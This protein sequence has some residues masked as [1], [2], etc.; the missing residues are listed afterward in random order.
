MM[1]NTKPHKYGAIQVFVDPANFQFHSLERTE[2][3]TLRFPSKYEYKVYC[4]LRLYIDRTN[5]QYPKPR[6]FL[7]LQY[8]ITLI[9]KGVMQSA[10]THVVD[11]IIRDSQSSINPV[12]YVEAKGQFLKEYCNKMKLM[13]GLKPNVYSRYLVISENNPPNTYISYY[14]Q[15]KKIEAC[16]YALGVK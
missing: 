11:F 10:I 15:L 9:S 16:L 1:T 6:Y 14:T 2:K 13:Q 5:R 4:G 7:E 8:Q 3:H 12:L